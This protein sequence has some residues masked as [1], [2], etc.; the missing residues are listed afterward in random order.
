LYLGLFIALTALRGMFGKVRGNQLY[1]TIL[2]GLFLFSAFRFRVGCDWL[3]Y[4]NQY[5]VAASLDYASAVG[6]QESLWWV[7]QVAFY[8]AGIPYPWVNVLVSAIFFI[9]IHALARRQPDRLG[10]LVL[11][12][13]ILIINMPMSAIRQGAAIG[14]ICLSMLALIDGRLWRFVA[15]TLLASTFH[16]SAL[17]FVVLAPLVS[18][19]YSRARL[20]MTFAMCAP[21]IFVLLQGDAA[22]LAVERYVDSGREAFGAIFRVAI[23]S[24]TALYFMGVLRKIWVRQF[25]KDYGLAVMGAWMMLVLLPLAVVSSVIG[26]RIG[27]YLIPIQ[28]MIFARIPFLRLG[29]SRQLQAALP[30]LGLLIVFAYWTLNSRLFALCYVPYQTW[31]FGYP[32]GVSLLPFE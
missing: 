32:E 27:Y 21:V 15:W 29:P 25:P 31:L 2:L 30:Y 8:R 26:D 12:F 3:G 13:P 6:G 17:I 14:I 4:Y 23:L 19:N 28:A 16:S 20:A 9:G 24:L 7:I 10:F 18:K 5:A 22:R 11:L 1:W